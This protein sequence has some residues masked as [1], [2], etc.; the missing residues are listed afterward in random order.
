VGNRAGFKIEWTGTEEFKRVLRDM[1]QDTSSVF[2]RE[3]TKFGMLVEE[4]A[5]ALAPQDR[6]DLAS[7]I[8]A[9][10]PNVSARGVSI[11]IG[12][13]SIY[14]AY[15]HEKRD[16]GPTYAKYDNGAKFPGYYSGGYGAR[17]RSK[18]SWRGARPGRKY[19]ERTVQL[20]ETDFNEMN[21]RILQQI[22]EGRR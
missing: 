5:R 1:T 2:Q 10:A 16:G 14:G 19:L 18:P 20:V 22:M 17:T 6:G 13:G 3:Y 8:N 12:V 7:T 9:D 11:E 4:G 21:E 15:Q